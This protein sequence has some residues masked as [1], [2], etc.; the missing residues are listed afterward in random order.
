MGSRLDFVP[1][2]FPN[3]AFIRLQRCHWVRDDEVLFLA[4]IPNI[5]GV[6]VFQVEFIHSEALR[7]LVDQ[8]PVLKALGWSSFGSD[9]KAIAAIAQSCTALTSV[10]LTLNVGPPADLSPLGKYRKTLKSLTLG[11]WGAHVP[12]FIEPAGLEAMRHLT[13]LTLVCVRNIV[14]I[15][16]AATASCPRLQTCAVLGYP[17]VDTLRVVG[18]ARQIPGA[19]L[20]RLDKP[21]ILRMLD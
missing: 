6:D 13:Y 12:I 16:K 8:K 5:V 10:A 7:G 3:L 9:T 1:N 20:L 11:G 14:D 2:L 18:E 21:H 4:S 17:T 15:L 19:H